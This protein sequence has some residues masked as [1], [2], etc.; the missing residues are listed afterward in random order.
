MTEDCPCCAQE[1]AIYASMTQCTSLLYCDGGD[2]FWIEKTNY[3]KAGCEAE[4]PVPIGA[5][6]W[7]WIIGLTVIA[8]AICCACINC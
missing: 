5:S 8:C 1:C 2:T 3:E 4:C 7:V 6:L